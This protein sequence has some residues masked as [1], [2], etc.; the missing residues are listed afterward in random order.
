MCSRHQARCFWKAADIYAYLGLRSYKNK[1]SKWV[2]ETSDV[3][4]NLWNDLF[5]GCHLVHSSFIHEGCHLRSSLE[6]HRRCLPHTGISTVGL[7]ACLLR[8][9]AVEA[10]QG[11]LSNADHRH[12]AASLLSAMLDCY[13]QPAGMVHAVGVVLGPWRSKWP[14]PERVDLHVHITDGKCDL[15]NLLAARAR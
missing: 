4:Q 13:A 9:S 15:S 3:W 11:G 12:S 14:V 5:G 8:W 2:Y 10:N 6:M 1:P 7:L